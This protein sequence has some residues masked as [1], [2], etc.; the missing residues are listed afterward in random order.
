[1]TATHKNKT[2]ATLL[3]ALA[4]SV[5][6]HRFYLFGKSDYWGWAHL[7]SLP[8]SLLI[9]HLYFG[10]QPLLTYSPIL[11]SFL[12][13][14]LEA[15]VIGL[16]PDEKWDARHNPQSPKKSSSS[17]PLALILVMTAGIGAITLIGVIA[18]AFDLL[19][20]GGAYG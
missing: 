8:I 14:L 9:S 3:A 6:A 12:I 5:G 11:L 16:T 7:I 4:G 18:R 15:L 10:S 2:F 17:W 19:Y 1:M 20:T 13:A